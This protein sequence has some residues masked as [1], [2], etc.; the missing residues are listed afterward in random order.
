MPR[1]LNKLKCSYKSCRLKGGTLYFKPFP[2]KTRHGMIAHKY[3]VVSHEILG[4][5]VN[6]AKVVTH[7]IGKKLPRR[8][9]KFA[10]PEDLAEI[11][12]T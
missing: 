12:K 1:P 5:N 9:E 7:Y 11:K 6:R 10:R 3:W 2:R 4:D 8:L